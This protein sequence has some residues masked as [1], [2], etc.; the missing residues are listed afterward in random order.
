MTG[1]INL[2][3]RL[4]IDFSKTVNKFTLLDAYPLLNMD[5][6]ANKIAQYRLYSTFDLRSAYHQIPIR[7][8]DKPYTAFETN[9]RLCHFNRVPFGVTNGGAAYHGQIN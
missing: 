8:C 1:K 4:V 9:G 7:D 5:I 3:P 2:R 6:L